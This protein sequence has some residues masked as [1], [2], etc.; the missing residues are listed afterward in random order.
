MRASGLV[1]GDGEDVDLHPYYRHFLIFPYWSAD[2]DGWVFNPDIGGAWLQ[3]ASLETV[4]F[5]STDPDDTPKMMSL[6]SDGPTNP[7]VPY[8]EG[9][10]GVAG[11]YQWPLFVV[12][13]ELDA[14]SI[15]DCG[16][17]A[18]A[19]NSASTWRPEW[20]EE[21]VDYRIPQIVVVAEGDA[22]GRRFPS[23]VAKVAR[24]VCGPE[25]TEGHFSKVVC[26]DGQDVNDLHMAGELR[27]KL[28]GVVEQLLERGD[29]NR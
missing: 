27:D 16:W 18:V 7:S 3:T 26:E 2:P 23:R 28:D 5:R 21:W 13:G 6:T 8:L 17:P 22:A 24:D 10:V 1:V 14:L 29:L 20:C 9:G 12:E 4:R 25:W 19:T 15:V 11:R